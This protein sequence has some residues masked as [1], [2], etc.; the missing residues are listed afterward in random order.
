MQC[1]EL[2]CVPMYTRGFVIDT[3]LHRSCFRV[4]YNWNF[5]W[6]LYPLNERAIGATMLQ[7]TDRDINFHI[8]QKII[9]LQVYFWLRL[10]VAKSIYRE[11]AAMTAEQ[12]QQ[13][14]Q[15]VAKTVDTAENC[16]YL[17]NACLV[18]QVRM[19]TIKVLHIQ[20]FSD[21]TLVCK[22]DRLLGGTSLR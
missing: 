10:T 6:R 8:L 22:D 11:M 16:R 7:M 14:Y 19:T 15:L 20:D 9:K 18:D 5:N 1:T 4:I 21:V 12:W 13:F 17:S 3:T 2:L